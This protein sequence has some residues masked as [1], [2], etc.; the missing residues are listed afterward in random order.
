[1]AEL[2]DAT[3]SKSVVRMDVSVRV[4]PEVPSKI[5]VI[6]T[7][8]PEFVDIFKVI[9]SGFIEGLTE[10]IPVSST[11]HLLLF[12][13]YVDLKVAKNNLF[14]IVIQFGAILAICYVYK[15]KLI[16]VCC[17]IKREDNQKFVTNLIVSFLPAAIIG[18][19]F[20]D[21]IKEVLFSPMIVAIA[22][23]VG[24]FIIIIVES[25]QKEPVTTRVDSISTKQALTMGL[26]Q[27]VAMIPGVSRSG[28]TIIGGL[29][30]GL[31]RRAAT[32]FSFFMSIVVISAASF[33]DLFK[34]FSEINTGNIYLILIGFVTAFF[35]SIL[36]IKWLIKYVSNND[37]VPFGIY[38]IMLGSIIL[39]F[40]L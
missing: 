3:D 7:R 12:S 16:L 22:L 25:I 14:E 8:M 27:V 4:G 13:W 11:A 17:Q 19:L 5:T 21:F 23:I 20:H 37:F 24:G 35:T 30:C 18:L 36:V 32:E 33:Y 39:F 9:I 40:I 10:F 26:Y 15:R 6:Y 38:R 31:N 34:N 1:M 2:V 28:A 29:L